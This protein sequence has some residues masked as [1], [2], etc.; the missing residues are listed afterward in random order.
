VLLCDE[1]PQAIN[2]DRGA[3][4][5]VLLVVE[6]PHAHFA[7]ITR[8]AVIQSIRITISKSDPGCR[9]L[10]D[11]EVGGLLF[12]EVD[13]VVVLASGITTTS[14]MLPVLSNTTMTGGNVSPLLPALLQGGGL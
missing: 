12:V 7:K 3:E 4:I 11:N 13:S 8:V 14:R 10:R 1:S 2:V 6:V 9:A 5:K